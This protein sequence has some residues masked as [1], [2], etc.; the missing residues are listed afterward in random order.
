MQGVFLCL[1]IRKGDTMKNLTNE[2]L[3]EHYH[4]ETDAFKKDEILN[5][6][7]R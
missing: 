5:L 4:N 3:I 6:F 7:F 1:T 2:E